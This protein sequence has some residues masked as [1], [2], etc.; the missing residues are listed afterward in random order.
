[1]LYRKNAAIWI[2]AAFYFMGRPGVL[3]QTTVIADPGL[4]TQVASFS[5]PDPVDP[6]QTNT[7]QILGGALLKVAS[8][9]TRTI[10]SDFGNTAQG[11][12]GSGGL[13]AVTWT[14]VGLLG[15]GQTILALDRE[16]GSH[17]DGALFTVDPST[18]KRT[19]LSDFGNAAQG[20]LGA[21]PIGVVV[22]N[23]LLGLGTQIYVLDSDAGTNGQGGLFR[24]D[25]STG[26]RTLLSDFGNAAQ[27]PLGA[28]PVS[29]AI[30]PAG[31]LSILGMNAGFLVLD[32][33]A[34][35]NGVGAVFAVDSN[36]NRS[37][38]SD[39]GDPSQGQVAISPQEIATAATGLLGLGTAIYVTDNELGTSESGEV[40]QIDIF[41]NRSVVTD[42]GNSAQGTLGGDE[43]AIAGIPGIGGNLLVADEY[44]DAVP[45]EAILFQVNPFTGQRTV[46]TDCNNTS[47][48]PCAQPIA[49]TQLP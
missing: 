12:T 16:A 2:F 7:A 22:A 13:T 3:A 42:F 18:G 19:V 34:G 4:G 6:T 43:H 21:D 17:D 47:L 32:N 49:V 29:I 44:L 30:A 45:S 28:N 26:N 36:G 11:P 35:T 8:N 38:F 40:F 48:G 39:L 27:G 37:L 31:L 25:P 15:L 23:G 41:G 14:P 1:M 20:Q 10:L 33:N 24:V 9:G 5:M 46:V